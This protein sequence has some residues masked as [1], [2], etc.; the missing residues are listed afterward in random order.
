MG[1]PRYPYQMGIDLGLV[2]DATAV[3]ITHAEDG[4]IVLDYHESW[5]AGVDWRVSNPHLEGRY[6]TDYARQIANATRL[7]FEAIAEWIVSLTKRFYISDGIF[8]R[9]TGIPLEQALSKA[10]LGQFKSEFF[11]KDFGSRIYQ[12]AKL[13]MYDRKLV[14]YD[15]PLSGPTQSKHSPFI[16]EML[17]LQ[18][19]QVSNNMVVVS[20]PESGGSHDDMSDAFVRA[21]WLSSQRMRSGKYIRGAGGAVTGA[22][23]T[24]MTL[25][26]YQLARA[27]RHGGFTERT[28]P[29]NFGM[30]FRG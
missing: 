29:R 22:G 5:T 23:A 8:D 3:F 26:R 4:K 28:V 9:W 2:N 11:T 30:R 20:A 27:R 6:S 17:S 19:E 1:M 12:N 7:D 16:Q 14:L 18:A 15:Y 21:V 25:G 13:L 24:S 10:G